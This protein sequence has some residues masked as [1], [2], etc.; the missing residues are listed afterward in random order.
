MN[1]VKFSLQTASSWVLEGAVV[2][3]GLDVLLIRPFPFL[4]F[5][6]S[7]IHNLLLLIYFKSICSRFLLLLATETPTCWKLHRKHFT[8][9][10]SVT[11]RN[12]R[13]NQTARPSNHWTEAAS[14]CIS[15]IPH[16]EGKESGRW[17]TV[18]YMVEG[19]QQGREEKE[20]LPRDV[21]QKW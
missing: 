7:H 6:C 5:K 17:N 2:E 10:S 4:A 11:G 13:M 1:R 15:E 3:L 8:S 21:S 14:P 9:I 19:G 16:G 12:T 18:R 20:N